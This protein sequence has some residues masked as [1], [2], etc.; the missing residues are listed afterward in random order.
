MDSWTEGRMDRWDS[1]EIILKETLWQETLWPCLDQWSSGFY[2]VIPRYVL[3]IQQFNTHCKLE[4]R[5]ASSLQQES[6]FHLTNTHTEPLF[7]CS[8][9]RELNKNYGVV[10]PGLGVC[11]CACMWEGSV[12]AVLQCHSRENAMY[13]QSCGE[14]TESLCMTAITPQGAL[15]AITWGCVNL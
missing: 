2:V 15:W 10:P 12:L 11:V 4:E 9:T 1:L 5:S 8:W 6:H 14:N 7:S 3:L 13:S